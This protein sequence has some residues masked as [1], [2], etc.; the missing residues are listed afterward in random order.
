MRQ[1]VQNLMRI[2]RALAVLR[3]LP[4][5]RA[6]SEWWILLGRNAMPP[7]GHPGPVFFSNLGHA[8]RHEA[9]D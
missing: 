2:G 5:H 1:T 7:V 3:S 9:P 4:N 6:M 8:S